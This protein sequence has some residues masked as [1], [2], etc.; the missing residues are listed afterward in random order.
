[1]EFEW[2]NFEETDAAGRITGY[3]IAW[4]EARV[5]A[6][7]PVLKAGEGAYW[8]GL[9]VLLPGLGL[10]IT[11][12]ASV[13]VPTLFVTGALLGLAYVLVWLGWRIPAAERWIVFGRDGVIHSSEEGRWRTQVADI[14]NIEWEEL[15]KRHAGPTL[16]P[17]GSPRTHYFEGSHLPSAL[18]VSVRGAFFPRWSCATRRGSGGTCGCPGHWLDAR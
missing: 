9:F 7:W 18:L 10:S 5:W 15:G 2:N 1:M 16:R 14:A 12:G 8:L 11:H 17:A 3:G 13:F 6:E 4:K